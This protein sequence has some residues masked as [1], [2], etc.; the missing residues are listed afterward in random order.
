MLWFERLAEQRIQEAIRDG[1][2]DD[3]EGAGRPLSLDD[4]SGVPAECRMAFR[5]LKNAG[6]LPEELALRKE[7]SHL[8]DLLADARDEHDRL[9]K[10]KKL[11]FMILKLNMRRRVSP[12]LELGQV[13][14]DRVVDRLAGE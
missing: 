13:Y 5:L 10:I 14:A 12:E 4:D 3:L 7:I 11:N 6:Y 1:A 2:L 9:A 8:Q